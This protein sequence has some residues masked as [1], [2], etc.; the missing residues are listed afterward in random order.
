MKFHNVSLLFLFV[1]VIVIV[2]G[3][4]GEKVGEQGGSTCKDDGGLVLVQVEARG[5]RGGCGG[6]W[7]GKMRR[8][9]K[10]LKREFDGAPSRKDNGTA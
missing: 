7:R 6:R 5:G 9:E 8:L 10:G 2:G 1:I 3:Q 4:S